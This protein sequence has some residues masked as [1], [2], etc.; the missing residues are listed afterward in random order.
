MFS[1]IAAQLTAT[2]GSVT[3]TNAST[4]Y[5]SAA[6]I[7]STNQTITNPYAIYV[8]SG[9]TRLDTLTC[10]EQ[11][12]T[13]DRTLK[14][15]IETI[16][17]SLEKINKMRGV[18]FDWKDTVKFNDRKQIGFIAQEVEEVAPELVYEAEKGI[19]S[20]NYAQTVSLLLQAMK[21][22]NQIIEDL[23]KDVEELKKNNKPKRT[24]KKK[25][26]TTETKDEKEIEKE[27]KPKKKSSKKNTE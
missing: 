6:P 20:V 21:E 9:T 3:T 19:K 15:N 11:T 1:G 13:S 5:I 14:T 8:G 7:A 2:N 16:D 22:Q 25:S 18:Y 4:L 24:Y 27:I 23:R 17:N 12:I 26:E 10:T